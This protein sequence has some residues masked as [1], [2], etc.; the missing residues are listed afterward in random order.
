MG[1][2]EK[3]DVARG[4]IDSL[5]L[6]MRMREVQE[7]EEGHKGTLDRLGWGPRQGGDGSCCG[8]NSS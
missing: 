3:R 7:A 2:V 1:S 4:V 6:V 5:E 8:N